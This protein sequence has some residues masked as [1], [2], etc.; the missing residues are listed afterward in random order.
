MASLCH[1]SCTLLRERNVAPSNRGSSTD[2]ILKIYRSTLCWVVT[3]VSFFEQSAL[4]KILRRYSRQSLFFAGIFAVARYCS[5]GTTPERL[6]L[7]C[8]VSPV[9]GHV[10]AG[11]ALRA[12]TELEL[13]LRKADRCLC[14]EIEWSRCLDFWHCPGAQA[15]SYALPASPSAAPRV[16]SEV[17]RGAR[18]CAP[19]GPAAHRDGRRGHGDAVRV[20]MGDSCSP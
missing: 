13:G 15:I 3:S 7:V 8:S 6:D 18:S 14:R 20:F 17:Q 10:D 2:I 12:A 1:K 11:G 19:L 9:S 4:C 5:K 16:A